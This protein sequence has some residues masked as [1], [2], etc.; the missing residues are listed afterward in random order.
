MDMTA[1]EIDYKF[2]EQKVN[3]A[4]TGQLSVFQSM[5]FM[6]RESGKQLWKKIMCN[7]EWLFRHPLDV[8]PDTISFKKIVLKTKSVSFKYFKQDK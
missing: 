1:L 4:G 6:K 8:K 3:Q 2:S 7:L 5:L